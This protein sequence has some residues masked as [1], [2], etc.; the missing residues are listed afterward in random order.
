[1]SVLEW[2]V[3]GGMIALVAI[4]IGV[5]KDVRD[6]D[7]ETNGKLGRAYQRLDEVKNKM[8]DTFTRREVCEVLHKQIRDD[9]TEVKMDI[10][11]L[12]KK[13]K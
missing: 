3:S 8:D 7:N 13:V 5:Y 6:R 1:M 4:L 12:I 11:T 2:I 10:K 9:L